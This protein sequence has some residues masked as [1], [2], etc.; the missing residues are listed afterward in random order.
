MRD[1]NFLEFQMAIKQRQIASSDDLPLF[2]DLLI[3]VAF[4]P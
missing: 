1:H 2:Q 4:T 3:G